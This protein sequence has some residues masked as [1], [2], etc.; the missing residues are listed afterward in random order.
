MRRIISVCTAALVMLAMLVATAPL[1]FAD[2]NRQGHFP[3][4]TTTGECFQDCT[5][6]T[7]SA[8]RQG[9]TLGGPGRHSQVVTFTQDNPG[10]PPVQTVDES[11]SGHN[12]DSGGGGRSTFDLNSGQT[13][14]GSNAPAPGC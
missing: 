4:T 1:A 5:I 3:P 6:T 2:K 11:D 7:T 8:G 14:R 13:C 9:N 10:D 12:P